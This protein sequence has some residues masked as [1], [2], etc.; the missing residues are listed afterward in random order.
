M[1]DAVRAV[2]AVARDSYGRLVGYLAGVTGDLAAAE[3]ALSDALEAALR[4]WPA[5]GVP[6]RPETWLITAARRRVIDAGRRRDTAVRALPELA[7]RWEEGGSADAT[8]TLPDDRLGLLF[9]CA[10][11]AIDPSAHS[12]LML[13]AVL[14]L[15]AAQIAA[16]FQVAPTTMG[17]RLVRAKAKIKRAGVPFRVPGRDELPERLSAVLDAVYAAYGTAWDDIERSDRKGPGLADEAIRLA[18]LLVELQP[19]EPEARGLLAL[20]LHTHARQEA[21]RD[22][23]GEF[24][25]LEEQDTSLWSRSLIGE[26]EAQLSAAA[27]LRALGPYQLMAAIQSVH[28]LR[29]ATGTTNWTVVVSLYDGLVRL[30]PSAGACV[31]RVAAYRRSAGPAAALDLLADLPEE[32]FG[33]YQPYWVVRAVCSKEVGLPNAAASAARAM[34]L[35]TSPSLRRHLERELGVRPIAG[36]DEP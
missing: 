2:E 36:S 14:G 29:A 6:D 7:R 9:A 8:R 33:S 23:A 11:P 35:T 15:D 1:A 5:R 34:E 3:D 18:R 28:N 20:L 27:A 26:A 30:A 22:R 19:A 12:P 31:A 17:Q 32:R 4:T 24:V 13:Q 21:R 16:A 25:A 10:H